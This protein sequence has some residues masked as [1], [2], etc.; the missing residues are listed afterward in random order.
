MAEI[1]HDDVSAQQTPKRGI[2][3]RILRRPVKAQTDSLAEPTTSTGL[4]F[5]WSYAEPYVRPMGS[6][7][8]TTDNVTDED[9]VDF[10]ERYPLA[11]RIVELPVDEA[12]TNGFRILIAGQES[13]RAKVLWEQNRMSWKRHFKLTRLFGHCAMIYG[14]TD[15]QGLWQ[16]RPQPDGVRYTWM[17]P[18]S[19]RYEQNLEE[20]EEFPNR[21][22]MYSVNYGSTSLIMLPDRITFSY[23]KSLTKDDLQ[24]ESVLLIAYN[25]LHVQIHSDWSIGQSFFRRASG[26]LALF[27]PKRSVSDEDKDT[28]MSSVANHNAK[29]VLYMPFGW[30]VKDVLKPGGNM[31]IARTYKLITEQLAAASGIP[32]SI[33]TAINT[34]S[35]ATSDDR[36]MFYKTVEDFRHDVMEPA[37]KDWI[38]KSQKAGMVEPGEITIDFGEFRIKDDLEHEREQTMIGAYRL[39]QSRMDMTVDPQTKVINNPMAPGSPDNVDLVKLLTAKK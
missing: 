38:R 26:L 2:I 36:A 1:A 33:L 19:K 22:K 3:D 29:T 16:E 7:F 39:M 8:P 10:H 34:P 30:N 32:E 9:L 11:K 18:A 21:M 28:A 15:E 6:L 25:L 31:A 5:P 35:E 23:M 17:A 4:G 24:G 14:W 12:I 37:L 27:A 20:K 13:E